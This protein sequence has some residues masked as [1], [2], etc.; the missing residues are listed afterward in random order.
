MVE[1]RV[2]GVSY[3]FEIEG[4]SHI[5][6]VTSVRVANNFLYPPKKQLI[7]RIS[8][9]VRIRACGSDFGTLKEGGSGDGY[10]V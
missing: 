1:N 10:V 6:V 3:L 2:Q 7:G 8:D 5:L 9:V 4:T